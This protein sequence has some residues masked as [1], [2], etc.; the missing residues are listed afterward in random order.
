MLLLHGF[1]SSAR[2]FR[3]I[4]PELSQ[5]AYVI[6]P[7]LPGFGG[8]ENPQEVLDVPELADSLAAWMPAI[9]LEQGSFL[10][11]SFGCQ[12]IADLAARYPGRVEKAILQG[13][14]T[15]P[16]ERSWF[17]QLVRL[18][19]CLYLVAYFYRLYRQRV[20]NLKESKETLGRRVL[21]RT[22]EL[23]RETAGRGLAEAEIDQVGR[24]GTTTL[25]D[26]SSGAPAAPRSTWSRRPP[27]PRR[28]SDWSFPSSTASFTASSA[29]AST[30]L[31]ATPT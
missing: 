31:R 24:D 17:W 8:S 29:A 12:V 14:T 19:A 20:R 25:G 10:G 13:P 5:A 30:S 2:T 21:Q 18:T 9:G 23:S 28:P 3:D 1:P 26:E 6:A 4:V 7:D 27:V 22:E 15:P 16:E 11:N